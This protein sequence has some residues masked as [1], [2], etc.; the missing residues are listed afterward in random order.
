M[1]E[2]VLQLDKLILQLDKLVLQMDELVLQLGKK[3]T[4]P[5]DKT[6]STAGYAASAAG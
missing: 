5:L 2:Q 6:G 4:L 1:G 3:V